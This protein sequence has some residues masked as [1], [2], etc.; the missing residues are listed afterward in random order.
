LG[1]IVYD[2]AD[3]GINGTIFDGDLSKCLDYCKNNKLVS[4]KLGVRIGPTHGKNLLIFD[5]DRVPDADPES[6]F[7]FRQHRR[8]W[9][10]Y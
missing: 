4:V 2:T 3:L 1:D 8:F 5:G 9:D 7:H 6:L 10:I